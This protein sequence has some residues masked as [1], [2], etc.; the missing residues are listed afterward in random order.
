M[1]RVTIEY[2]IEPDGWWAESPDLPRWTAAAV[3]YEELRDLVFEGLA[4]FGDFD[5]DQTAVYELITDE[6]LAV[7]AKSTSSA[8]AVIVTGNIET[9]SGPVVE[10]VKVPA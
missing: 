9:S 6:R 7:E 3:T 2:H 8:Q 4:E 1:R 10:W 5:P